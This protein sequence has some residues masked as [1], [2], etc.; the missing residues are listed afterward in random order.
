M[1]MISLYFIIRHIDNKDGVGTDS[2]GYITLIH[3]DLAKKITGKM[4]LSFVHLYA[5]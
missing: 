5:F 3:V 4:Y 1:F 2:L